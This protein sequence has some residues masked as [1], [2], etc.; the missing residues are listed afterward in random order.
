MPSCSWHPRILLATSPAD[1]DF[2]WSD[3][4][5]HAL[6]GAFVKDFI[7]ALPWRHPVEWA[8]NY[9]LQYPALSI[10]FYPPLF[11]FFEAAFYAVFGVN[12]FAAQATVAAFYALLGLGVYRLARLW[13]P[14]F[15]ALGSALMLMGAPEITLWGRQ[16]ML[17]IP[18]MAWLSG[19]SGLAPNLCAPAAVPISPS[20]RRCC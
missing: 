16:V 12:H 4:P 11:Y 1:G 9:Y 13:L 17:D 15:T 5:R 18:A 6:N 8:E 19:A 3:A 2:S 10:L 7:A 20:A 14:R